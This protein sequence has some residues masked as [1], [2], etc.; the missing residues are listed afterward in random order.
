MTRGCSRASWVCRC[1]FACA[2]TVYGYKQGC[3][4]AEQ[5]CLSA[6]QVST[7]TPAHFCTDV[8]HAVACTLD[9]YA[10]TVTVACENEQ[11]Q[12]DE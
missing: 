6:S 3:A 7:G 5:K 4:F 1:C 9:R 12:A 8:S 2:G 10:T 11:C